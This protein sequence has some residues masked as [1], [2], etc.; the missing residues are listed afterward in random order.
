MPG[1]ACCSFHSRSCA[2]EAGSPFSRG[3][4]TIAEDG[5]GAWPAS[6]NCLE[7]VRHLRNRRRL[8]KAGDLE[9]ELRDLVHVGENVGGQERVAAQREE[10]IMD[11]DLLDLEDLCPAFGQHLLEGRPRRDEGPRRGDGA[12][13]SPSFAAKPMRCTLP[14]GPFGISLTMSTWRGT[15]KSARRPMAN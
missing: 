10:I 1:S 13:A 11:A 2:M 12:V 8:E 5:C 4:R 9:L 3:T 6:I 15:L 14:V 7:M